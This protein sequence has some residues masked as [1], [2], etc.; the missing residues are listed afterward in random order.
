MWRR[1]RSCSL[2]F[3]FMRR[4][5]A[6]QA[7]WL[8]GVSTLLYNDLAVVN[9]GGGAARLVEEARWTTTW[10]CLIWRNQRRGSVSVAVEAEA[11]EE[12]AAAVCRRRPARWRGRGGRRRSQRRPTRWRGEGRRRGVETGS[13]AA[14][15]AQGERKARVWKGRARSDRER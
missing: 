11:E 1:R 7:E 15:V 12:V 14:A 5:G 6:E 10:W 9:R 8:G 2:G 4:D 3:F 13:A